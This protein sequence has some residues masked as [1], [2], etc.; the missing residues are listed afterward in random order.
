MDE[1]CEEDDVVVTADDDS[2]EVGEEETVT[3][4]EWV[5]LSSAPG[6]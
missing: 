5:C 6:V 2:V 4:T 1:P 3:V